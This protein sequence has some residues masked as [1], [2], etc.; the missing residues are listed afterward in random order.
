MASF[1]DIM[2]SL[3]VTT[4]LPLDHKRFSTNELT[5][6]DLGDSN[7]LAFTYYDNLK[8]FCWNEKTEW[9]W[10]EVQDGEENTGLVASDFVYPNG[11]VYPSPGYEGKS[12]NFFEI[13]P[14][15]ETKIEAGTDI[16]I[17]GDG[18][19]GDPYVINSN[20]VYTPTITDTPPLLNLNEGNGIGI[21][22]RSRNPSF[23]G[24]IG[25]NAFDISY[26]S[27]NDLT[28]G[29]TGSH[30][31]AQGEAVISS[32]VHSMTMGKTINN[33]GD[34]SFTCGKDNATAAHNSTTGGLHN[35]S[36]G[37]SNTVFGVANS[38]NGVGITILGQAA[39]VVSTGDF[40]N[41]NTIPT[42]PIL[43]V[44]NGVVDD[45]TELATSRSDAFLVRYNGMIEAPSM[46]I[47]GITSG[48]ARTLVT[49]EYVSSIIAAAPY[50]KYVALL[51]QTGTGVN[52][53]TATV[54]ESDLSGTIVW[55][56]TLP[57]IY[58]G[59][60]AAEFVVNK[61]FM[62]TQE[63]Y[64]TRIKIGSRSINSNT[65]TIYTYDDGTETDDLLNKTSVEIR[66]YN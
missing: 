5:L 33:D 36:V 2:T 8:V 47:A 3:R 65:V 25:L 18:S 52:S 7:N 59:T 22:V 61:T 13:V 1:T 26:S 53:V 34:Y 55:T 62:I 64:N 29:A 58:V 21:V 40:S 20:Y 4:Q 42:K 28:R 54:L 37:K 16:S 24:N 27:T 6:A 17:T 11:I 63:H 56:R 14:G 15:T 51:T 50:K 45:I 10:R 49:K 38:A 57:G 48:T 9:V 23:F 31:F 12:Y 46:T 35:I 32:G 43:A 60:L 66:I 41:F 39:T 44:G 30:S 19:L